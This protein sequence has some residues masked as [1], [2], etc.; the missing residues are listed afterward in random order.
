MVRLLL[1]AVLAV[2][3]AAV[4]SARPDGIPAEVLQKIKSATVLVQTQLPPVTA[5]GTGFVV[6]VEG[7][8]AIIVTSSR[9]LGPPKGAPGSSRV[10]FDSGRKGERMYPTELLFLDRARDLAIL[11]VA[12]A[13]DLPE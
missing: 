1:A 3:L 4:G 2:L 8:S 7:N 10:M 6:K 11:R 5:V 13:R 9:V 12:R